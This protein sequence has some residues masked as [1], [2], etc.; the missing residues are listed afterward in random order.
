MHYKK[1]AENT[2]AD[3]ISRL[4][5]YGECPLVQIWTSPCLAIEQTDGGTSSSDPLDQADFEWMEDFSPSSDNPDPLELP[6]NAVEEDT[7]HAPHLH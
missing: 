1:G 4:P 7:Q 3:A 5:T 6:V 2:I